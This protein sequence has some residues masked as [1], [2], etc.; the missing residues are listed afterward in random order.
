MDL[1]HL[2]TFHLVARRG[3]LA[4]AAR[5]LGVPTST[6]SRSLS[7]LELEFGVDLL[8]R[9]TRGVTL[10]EAGTELLAHSQAPLAELLELKEILSSDTPRGVLRL[11]VPSNLANLEW[12]AEL[13]LGFQRLHPAI[14]LDIALS[15]HGI[16]LVDEGRDVA[17]RLTSQLDPSTDVIAR[18]LPSIEVRLFASKAYLAKHGRPA[19]L[20]DLGA[21]RRLAVRHQAS[22]PLVLYRDHETR[23]L[24]ARPS[25]VGDD[26]SFILSMVRAGAGYAPIPLPYIEGAPFEPIL[27]EWKLAPLQPAIIWPRRRFDVPRVRAFVDFA[28]AG[29][30]RR[31][32]ATR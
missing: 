19:S 14:E 11:S 32:N 29:F 22:D 23:T 7:R 8:H 24:P 25:V 12:F 30:E 18:V 27:P 21:H 16:H 9:G 20:N 15:A 26:L 13:L 17:F 10:T 6:V 4:G 28:V 2:R 5:D 3:S 1:D 31:L